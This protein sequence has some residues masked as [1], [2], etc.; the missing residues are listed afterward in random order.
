MTP[1]S[2][3]DILLE[4]K[5]LKTKQSAR[6]RYN[7]HKNYQTMPWNICK[8]F[9]KNYNRAIGMGI[10][11]DDMK[12]AK[13]IAL[14]KKGKKFDLNNYRPIS[15]LSHFDKIFEKILCKRLISFLKNNKIYYCHQFG[16]RK[17]TL[18]RWS[19][20]K[21]LIVL[22]N[23]LMKKNYVVG[24]FID[25]R[26][27]FDTVDHNILLSKL[28]YYHNVWNIPT[29]LLLGKSCQETMAW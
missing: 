17:G 12:I 28:D 24:I 13:V 21:L 18:Q 7:R 16:F 15:L 1:I 10:Y 22:N 14:F 4:I 25:F 2:K 9:G 11:P 8:Y 6:S 23:Y 19:S 29:I 27:A 26:K 3:E 20:R 5:K